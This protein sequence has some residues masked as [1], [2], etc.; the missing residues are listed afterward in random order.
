M[1]NDN[2]TRQ[3]K[4]FVG[5][6][7]AR[8]TINTRMTFSEFYH[9]QQLNENWKS[10]AAGAGL[11]AIAGGGLAGLKDSGDKVHG[12]EEPSRGV[13]YAK[14]RYV[15]YAKEYTNKLLGHV[16]DQQIKDFGLEAEI[17]D[18]LV[19][20]NSSSKDVERETDP[21]RARNAK[22]NLRSALKELHD[23]ISIIKS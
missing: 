5:L 10:L 20:I 11:A 13:S 19:K 8:A 2:H 4:V 7:Q 6:S 9:N 16:T 21:T 23:T 3:Q 14:E 22:G 18:I 17:R 15:D 1:H 12:I